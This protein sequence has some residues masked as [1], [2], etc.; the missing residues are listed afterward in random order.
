MV[1]DL[2]PH[3]TIKLVGSALSF[4]LTCPY[5]VGVK[6]KREAVLGFLK[7]EWDV[8]QINNSDLGKREPS[9]R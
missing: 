8:K 3:S 7:L 9:F 1:P 5:R 6:K 4:S 2:P